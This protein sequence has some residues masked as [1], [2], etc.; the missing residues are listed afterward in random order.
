MLESKAADVIRKYSMLDISDRVV[1]SVSGG[2]DSLALLLYLEELAP[3]MKLDLHVF[4]LDHMIR[5]EESRQE[6]EFVRNFSESRGL[7]VE[8]VSENVGEQAVGSRLSKQ[9][10][11]R[12]VRLARLNEYA[13]KIGAARIAVG[14]NADDQVETYL[15]RIIQGAGLTGLRG[16]QPVSGRLIRP[17]IETWRSEIEEYLD[18]KG[19]EPKIDSSNLEDIYL[20]NRIR[21]RLVPYLESEFGPGTKAVF[22]REVGCLSCDFDYI[23]REV[24]EAFGRVAEAGVGEVRI[25]ICLLDELHVAIQRGVIREAWSRI[26]TGGGGLLWTHVN[27][28]LSKVVRGNSGAAAELPGGFIAEREYGEL[29]IRVRGADSVDKGSLY[30]DVPGSIES[31]EG[32]TVVAEEV[33][34]SDVILSDDPSVEYIKPEVKLPLELRKPCP[35]DRFVPLGYEGTKKLKDYFI[36][37][38]LPRRKRRSCELLISDGD[39]VWVIGHRLDQRFRIVPG[40][41]KAIKLSIRGYEHGS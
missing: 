34:A 35:G 5:G 40:N 14:H 19:V 24:L 8:V 7:P 12:E 27:D 16:I 37:S 2:P 1:V 32:Y 21:N 25:N 41:K 3:F 20:R 6:A 18:N 13:D 4:H 29:V 9:H 15:M 11:A 17:L 22:L 23:Q 33:D 30:L 10:F 39:I 38:K 26:C 31:E 36:D 28:I